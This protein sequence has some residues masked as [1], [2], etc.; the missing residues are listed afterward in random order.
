MSKA[1]LTASNLSVQ[2][3]ADELL[4]K[5]S[6]FTILKGQLVS[7]CYNNDYGTLLP[8]IFFDP[9]I[10]YKGSFRYHDVP[11][12]KKNQISAF[13]IA[14]ENSLIPLLS[15]VDNVFAIQKKHSTRALY[16]SR[17][18]ETILRV[19]A[20][21]SGLPIDISK[22]VEELSS[23][24]KYMLL[25][26]KAV[27]LNYEVI[28]M[29]EIL[30]ECRPEEIQW[31]RSF[32]EAE[33]SKGRTF[34][35]FLKSIS[36]LTEMSDVLYIVHNHTLSDIVFRDQYSDRMFRQILY[37][38]HI[39]KLD[40]R[41]TCSDHRHVMAELKFRN[42]MAR[43]L[44]LEIYAD[45]VFGIL[46]LYGGIGR[47]IYHSFE[48]E[49][50]YQ[51]QGSICRTYR[52]AIRNGLAMVSLNGVDPLFPEYTLEENLSFLL[53]NKISKGL[54]IKRRLEKY[55]TEQYAGKLTHFSQLFEGYSRKMQILIYRWLM[56]KPNLMVIE[57]PLQTDIEDH[58]LQD[59]QNAVNNV[60]KEHCS[61][62]YLTNMPSTCFKL[63]DRVMIVRDIGDYR[64]FDLN[65]KADYEAAVS[66]LS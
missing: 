31:I 13:L 38:K 7:F 50:P 6:T 16:S 9:N 43:E 36:L 52:E 54:V 18:A 26:F 8:T 20:D 19:L 51:I 55:I 53:W 14:Q 40:R 10:R 11:V 39:Q 37:G 42:V 46:D 64:I 25:L 56:I 32:I 63:C 27:I 24:Q 61:V 29:N 4:L 5:N 23:A 3:G 34:I 44:R 17:R 35:F 21:Q 41:Q 49:F 65:D 22:S 60:I 59:F 45:E 47:M 30:S 48:C 1:I 66:E 15:I 62:L 33:K 28:L 2:M 58:L 57:N 12:S